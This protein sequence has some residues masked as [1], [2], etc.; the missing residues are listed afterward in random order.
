MTIDIKE[1]L[2]AHYMQIESEKIRK[3][4]V[5][6]SIQIS[7]MCVFFFHNKYVIYML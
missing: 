2:G 3:G 6:A 5:F 1:V 7:G 4:Q